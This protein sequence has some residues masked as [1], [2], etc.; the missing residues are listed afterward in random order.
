MH[1]LL[2]AEGS[3]FTE[4]VLFGTVEAPRDGPVTF[5]TRY[6]DWAAH[7]CA[8][9]SLMALGFRLARR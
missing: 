4:E 5:Y 6:G 8:A 9:V 7:L 3:P 1:S 2:N